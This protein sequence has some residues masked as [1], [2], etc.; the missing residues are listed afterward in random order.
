M[1]DTEGIALDATTLGVAITGKPDV[2][3]DVPQHQHH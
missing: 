2:S 3:V 1:A